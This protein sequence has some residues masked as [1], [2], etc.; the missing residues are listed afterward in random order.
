MFHLTLQAMKD[1]IIKT[2]KTDRMYLGEHFYILCKGKNSG[3]PLLQPCANCWV[4]Q[5]SSKQDREN[6]YWM[7]YTLWQ[8]RF[9]HYFLV[10]S[11]IPFLR[12]FEFKKEFLPKTELLQ[13]DYEQHLRNVL[14]LQL[15]QEKEQQFKRK[16]SLIDGAKKMILQR[17]V[18]R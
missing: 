5:F 15:L 8:S 16:L 10:G 11:V 7:A 18:Q 14:A 3:K 13:S 12:L 6:Y 4:L 2:H 17:Y 9:W 1:L